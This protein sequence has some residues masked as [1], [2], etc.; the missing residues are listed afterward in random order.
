VFHDPTTGAANDI[1]KASALARAMVT[2]Y[3]MSARLG[4]LKFGTNASEPFLGRDFGHQ[5]D[6]SEE[7]AAEIDAEVRALIQAAHDQAWDI[8]VANRDVL[9]ALV[10]ELLDRETLDK[11]EVE[12]VFAGIRKSA[13]RPPWTGS[14]H[15]P[16]S[17]IPPVRS[18][19]ELARANGSAT[20]GADSFAN[21]DAP[22][23][24]PR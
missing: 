9:D 19:A 3:G 5:R 7:V 8:L 2:Q 23:G 4:A 18:R 20:S 17:T 15:R 13:P 10:V 11:A 6:Y 16:P 1:E 12:E 24:G 21:P 22:A 14:P